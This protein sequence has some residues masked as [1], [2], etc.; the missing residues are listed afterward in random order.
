MCGHGE[1]A[2]SDGPLIQIDL[3]SEFRLPARC[4]HGSQRCLRPATE[5]PT[6]PERLASMGFGGGTYREEREDPEQSDQVLPAVQLEGPPGAGGAA[7]SR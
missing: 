1:P 6:R 7:D 3:T 4:P 5:R 2:L